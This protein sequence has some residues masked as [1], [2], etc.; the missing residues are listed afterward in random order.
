VVLEE[1]ISRPESVGLGDDDR[2]TDLLRD[3]A[4]ADSNDASASAVFLAWCRRA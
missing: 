3:D 2:Q 4:G 1:F